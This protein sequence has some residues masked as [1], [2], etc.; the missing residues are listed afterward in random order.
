MRLPFLDRQEEQRRLKIALG[1]DHASLCCLYGR[2]R[3]GKSRLLVE[4]AAGRPVVLY[5]GDDRDASLQRRSLAA[6]IVDLIEGF[7]RVEYPDWDALLDRWWREAP[8]GALLVLDE[9]PSMVGTAPELP[10]LLQ[11]RFDQHAARPVHLVLC[12]SSQRMMQGLVLDSHAPLYGRAREIIEVLPLDVAW[13]SAAFGVDRPRDVLQSFAVWGGVPRYWEL[14]LDHPTHAGAV[15]TLVLNPM[16]VLH[17]EPERLLM[18]DMREITKAASILALIGQGCHKPSAIAARLGHPATALARPLQRLQ[19]LGLVRREVP[20]GVPPR[21]SKRSLY[22]IA[23]P[24]LRF[25]FRY[26]EPNR[27]RL[28]AGHVELVEQDIARSWAVYLGGIWEDLARNAVPKIALAGTRWGAAS[29]WWGPG[30]DRI[31]L[32]VDIVAE[33]ADGKSLLVGEAKLSSAGV[34]AKQAA[35]ELRRKAERL[36]IFPDH[37]RVPVHFILE[38]SPG[39]TAGGDLMVTGRTVL[40]AGRLADSACS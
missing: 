28:Q 35:A 29:R 26:V 14:A 6:A 4:V 31:P 36:P 13:L 23:D 2:R 11:K 37:R 3:C 10:S 12:G 1:L 9:F 40:D 19:Q 38:E 33:S 20:F 39:T 7:D 18:D 17:R 34:S 21:D 15:R 8:P 5:V 24:F 25:W 27:S 22:R 32:E 16:G 30:T